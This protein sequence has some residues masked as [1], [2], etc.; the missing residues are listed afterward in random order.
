MLENNF[1]KLPL[2]AFGELHEIAFVEILGP[3][4]LS[5]CLSQQWEAPDLKPPPRPPQSRGSDLP[6]GCLASSTGILCEHN[7]LRKPLS[8]GNLF[9]KRQQ[10]K[11]ENCKLRLSKTDGRKREN[12]A[13]RRDI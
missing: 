9:G 7:S 4:L 13:W 10:N 2:G 3:W 11:S 6:L 5:S 12:L 1:A 8:N